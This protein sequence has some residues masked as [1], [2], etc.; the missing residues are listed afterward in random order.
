MNFHSWP[1]DHTETG[2]ALG[3]AIAALG[4]VLVAIG[5]VIDRFR[6]RR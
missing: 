2:I 5:L 4:G 3:L 6:H 1:L